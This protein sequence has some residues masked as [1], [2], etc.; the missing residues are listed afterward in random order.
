MPSPELL[1]EPVV[2]SQY[3]RQG[4]GNRMVRILCAEIEN[5]RLQNP[6]VSVGSVRHQRACCLARVAAPDRAFS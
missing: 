4:G 6:P 1:A 5:V 3:G 2:V